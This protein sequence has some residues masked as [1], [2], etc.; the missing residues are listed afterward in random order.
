MRS[1]LF[2]P[3][4]RPDLFDKALTSDADALSFD[5][6]D[7]VPADGK[8]QARARLVEFLRSESVRASSKRLIIRINA[9]DTPYAQDDLREFSEAEFC[10]N[11]PKVESPETVVTIAALTPAPLLLNI[12]TPVGVR[13]AAEIGRAHP[14]VIGLQVGMNDLFASLG[15]DRRNQG[16][17]HL[18][19]WQIRLAAGEAGCAVFDGAWP[20]IAD[21]A[22]FRAEAELARSL[23][24]LGKSCIHPAQVPI[25]NEIFD[26]TA[27]VDDAKRL[28]EAADLA[29]ARGHGA[30]SF[31]G[32]MVDRPEI[33]RARATLRAAGRTT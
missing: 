8:A 12:E 20:D 16:H 21:E 33:D 23:G 17:V 32:R 9:L 5:L 2:V 13:R 7:S 26:G 14:R 29:A 25:A 4:A 19:L 10:I 3:G 18:A 28:V 1:K 30:F 27:V 15:F 6:E 22:G 31:E 24:Y 11:I